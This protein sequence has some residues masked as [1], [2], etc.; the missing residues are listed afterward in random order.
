MPV[1]IN[2]AVIFG[3]SAVVLIAA[4]ATMVPPP[5]EYGDDFFGGFLEGVQGS[6]SGLGQAW[7]ELVAGEWTKLND[8]FLDGLGGAFTWGDEEQHQTR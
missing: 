5:G 7:G 8:R 3:L 4:L 6:L 2:A 1:R